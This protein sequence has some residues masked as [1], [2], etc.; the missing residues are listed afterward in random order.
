MRSLGYLTCIL[1]VLDGPAFQANCSSYSNQS[2]GD[3]VIG[4]NIFL[5]KTTWSKQPP[6]SPCLHSSHWLIYGWET[7]SHVLPL[8]HLLVAYKLAGKGWAKIKSQ[9]QDVCLLASYPRGLQPFHQASSH[10]FFPFHFSFLG[11]FFSWC[12]EL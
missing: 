3:P 7:N 8:L 12:L 10:R 5:L 2:L 1:C 11:L 9:G 6:L 4:V